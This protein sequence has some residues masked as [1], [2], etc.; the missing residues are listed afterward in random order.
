MNELKLNVAVDDDEGMHEQPETDNIQ[1]GQ[2]G[3]GAR[4]TKNKR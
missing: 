2:D 1:D 4:K 3:G